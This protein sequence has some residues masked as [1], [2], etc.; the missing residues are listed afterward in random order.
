MNI[1]DA[2]KIARPE[3]ISNNIA[4]E[5]DRGTFRTA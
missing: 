2:W 5:S 4:S 1:G 3:R